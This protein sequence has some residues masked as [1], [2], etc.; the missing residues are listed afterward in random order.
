MSERR[1]LELRLEPRRIA[2]IAVRPCGPLP[3]VFPVRPASHRAP[4]ASTMV[5]LLAVLI[6]DEPGL[7]E[8]L[9]FDDG[10]ELL[11]HVTRGGLLR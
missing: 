5:D 8:D 9:G 10:D 1:Q 11:N 7:V 3:Q 6:Q 4:V 2:V